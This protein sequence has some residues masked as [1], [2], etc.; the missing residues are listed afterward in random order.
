M[1]SQ[2]NSN[3]SKWSTNEVKVGD[4]ARWKPCRIA[5]KS[6]PSSSD[7][8]HF[9]TWNVRGLVK[10]GKLANVIQEMNR[11]KADILGISETFWKDTGEFLYSIPTEKENYK[12]I[13][14]GGTQSRKGVAI[15]MN[16]KIAK[17]MIYYIPVSERI[18]AMKLKDKKNDM[19]LIQ[20]YAPNED[21]DRNDV[22]SFYDELEKVIKE[23]KKF[24]DKLIIAGDFNAKV[25]NQYVRHVT[26]KFGLGERN[27]NGERLIEFCKKHG[28]SITNTF[29]E[30]KETSRHTWTSPDGKTKNQIDYMLVNNRFR[31]SIKN[32]KSRPGA[33]CGS[34]HNPVIIR[35]ETKLKCIK[36]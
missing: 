33:D 36:K 4:S 27:N 7:C 11:L 18:M 25:G 32:S 16:E 22:E 8:Y 1:T 23:N 2:K 9:A 34:D 30:Q 12:I 5:G 26:G 19:L 29:F 3:T 21:A 17:A 6:S 15:I 20:I 10:L 24:R 31:N 35:T 13:F 28:M 14:S